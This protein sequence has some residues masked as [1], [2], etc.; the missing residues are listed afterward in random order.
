MC[1]PK[2]QKGGGEVDYVIFFSCKKLVRVHNPNDD[3]AII[4]VMIAKYPVNRILVNSGSLA[5]ILS[6]GAFVWMNLS[7][8]HLKP[9][10]IPFVSFIIDLARIEG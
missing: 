4:F 6:C 3:V 1:T 7:S 10:I 9:I 2:R 8:S 5:N